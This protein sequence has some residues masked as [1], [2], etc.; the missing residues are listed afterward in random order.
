MNKFVK[1][2]LL[3]SLLTTIPPDHLC[4]GLKDDALGFFQK[5][6]SC[7]SSKRTNDQAACKRL[8]KALQA[9]NSDTWTDE[10]VVAVIAEPLK[11]AGVLSCTT[12]ETPQSPSNPAS[13]W[14]FGSWFFRPATSAPSPT[15]AP[16][17]PDDDDVEFTDLGGANFAPN[18]AEILW[19][20]TRAQDRDQK[21]IDGEFFT[22]ADSLVRQLLEA[23][24]SLEDY[25]EGNH[26]ADAG[27]S[28]EEI[29]SWLADIEYAFGQLTA[30]MNGYG[31]EITAYGIKK[32][33][34]PEGHQTDAEPPSTSPTRVSP[35][36]SVVVDE[37]CADVDPLSAAP[38][39]DPETKEA[40]TASFGANPLDE[41]D[42]ES[43]EFEG[44]EKL[45]GGPE[46]PDPA[47]TDDLAAQY[48]HIAA[49]F[50]AGTQQETVSDDDD[51][52]PPAL[53]E[54]FVRT[55]E[56]PDPAPAADQNPSALPNLQG[57]LDA[58]DP[59]GTEQIRALVAAATEAQ[60]PAEEQT[61][62]E[63]AEEIEMQE[64]RPTPPADPKILAMLARLEAEAAQKGQ[65]FGTFEYWKHDGLPAVDNP[66]PPPAAP[67]LDG[68]PSP[69]S[70]ADPRD[71]QI[72]PAEVEWTDFKGSPVEPEPTPSAAPA[73]ENLSFQERRAMFG[74]QV[75]SPRPT[76]PAPPNSPAAGIN[77]DDLDPEPKDPMTEAPTLLGQTPE[78]LPTS[79]TLP[80]PAPPPAPAPPSATAT[81]PAAAEP[82]P[83][84]P[85]T[86]G[87]SVPPGYPPGTV[88]RPP[89]TN[90]PGPGNKYYRRSRNNAG[91]TAGG[92]QRPR[93]KK[94][95][96]G[97]RAG[98]PAEEDEPD[99]SYSDA[100]SQDSDGLNPAELPSPPTTAPDV[101]PEDL[102]RL[103]AMLAGVK[104]PPGTFE[105]HYPQG[106]PPASPSLATQRP[107]WPS[108]D[109]RYPV[110]PAPPPPPP[111]NLRP[112]PDRLA[113][114]PPP[115]PKTSG[116]RPARKA[117][118]PPPRR[119]SYSPP[120]DPT[121]S[122]CSRPR[123]ATS[124]GNMR[125]DTPRPKPRTRADSSPQSPGSGGDYT[126]RGSTP[127]GEPGFFGGL[128][129]DLKG[130]GRELKD[131]WNSNPY[132][133]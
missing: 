92:G 75:T 21:Q 28:P 14:G 74:A 30:L 122:F 111:D 18:L 44:L 29:T 57:L 115:P 23:Q 109:Q 67:T 119:P 132:E 97:S 20:L 46:D 105:G 10:F 78:E 87:I 54:V 112:W 64:V 26:P 131:L 128:F 104:G 47:T 49:L 125:P 53:E 15:A 77:L 9:C 11:N 55:E 85:V 19:F 43:N 94:S 114:P 84:P 25:L 96:A 121:G 61:P 33:P 120:K 95:S 17:A 73:P 99:P 12:A 116:I 37:D 100:S 66:I 52:G 62:E 71:S 98:I 79:P 60:A 106:P 93:A 6:S 50:G 130:V 76:P 89:K 48:P 40:F 103:N 123:G 68:A 129:N 38:L 86:S 56:G 22:L 1:K 69:V 90:K 35:T 83:S 108:Q 4:A 127:R 110:R 24:K 133:D 72:Q 31:R 16:A 91:Q 59:D 82:P 2:L 51:D 32:L 63:P 126:G 36:T 58:A 65:K 3:I 42:P 34:L 102:R 8:L 7:K 45:F 80:I 70:T 88:V 124:A 118:P 101:R 107:L 113:P 5:Y 27:V 39:G 81:P 13:S 41:P 117:P